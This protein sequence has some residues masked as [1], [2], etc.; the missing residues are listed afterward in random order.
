[1]IGYRWYINF[2]SGQ[3]EPEETTYPTVDKARSAMEDYLSSNFP[4]SACGIDKVEDDDGFI[5]VLEHII[6]PKE[7]FCRGG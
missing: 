3:Y 5:E 1:M 2:A 7:K 4:R 6:L